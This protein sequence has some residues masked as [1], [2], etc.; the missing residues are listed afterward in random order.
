MT[1]VEKA[2]VRAAIF[3]HLA[4]IVL[5]PTVKALAERNVFEVFDR[6]SE[7]IELDQIVERSQGNRGYLRVALR[8]LA[9]CGWMKQETDENGWFARYALTPKGQIAVRIAPPLYGK[10]ISFIPK[11]VF[12]EDFLYGKSDEPL[13]PSLQDLVREASEGW[14]IGPAVDEVTG[15][16]HEE[17]RGHLNG[18]LVG[19]TMVALARGGVFARLEQGPTA[20][21]SLPANPAS[22]SCILDLLAVQGWTLRERNRLSL[23]PCG[24]YAAQIATSYGVTVSYLPLFHVLNTLLF[25]NPRIPRFDENGAEL[26]VNRGMNVWG[27][28]GAHRTYFQKVDEIIIEIF[29]RPLHLQ[30]RGI[31][32]MGCGDGTLL[33]HLYFVVKT[34]TARGR[35]L[36]KHP[37]TLIGADFNKVARRVTKRTLH[38]AEIPSF[39]VIPGDINRPAQLAG[40]LEKLNLDIHD[41]LHVRSFLDHNRPYSSPANYVPGTRAGM[42]SGAFAH[43]G[44]EIPAD[45]LEENLVRHLRRWAPYVGRFGLLVLELHTLPPEVT[46]S[47]LEKT[48]AIAYDG[49]HGFSDQYL[50]ELPIFLECAREAGLQ[51]DLRFQHKFPPSELATVSINFFTTAQS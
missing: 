20:A 37:L 15:M 49:T 34:R 26:L 41:L 11:A 25:G 50:V 42:S 3:N 13:L 43:L 16:V 18:M 30:P 27:S 39:Y 9:S 31:C 22:L 14:C 1:D 6:A 48:P 10:V 33:E 51:A 23:T 7:W 35:V 47:N 4:G 17:I 44:R 36:E 28:G 21:E 12:L 32:D 8:L 5:A 29:N 24:R 2:G 46:A 40:D 45:E 38:Q 19:P